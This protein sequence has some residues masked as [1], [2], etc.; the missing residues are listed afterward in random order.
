MVGRA[1]NEREAEDLSGE[2]AKEERW[3]EGGE[4]CPSCGEV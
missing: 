4:N 2:K 3:K 1:P